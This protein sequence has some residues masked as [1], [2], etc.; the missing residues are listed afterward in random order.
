MRKVHNLGTVINFEIMRMLKKPGFWVMALGF[1]LIF[2]AI[3]GIIFWSNQATAEAAKK[4][5]EQEFSV[6]ILDHSG[7]VDQQLVSQ[8]KFQSVSSKQDG[9]ERVKSQSLDGFVYVP[10]D[11]TKETVEVYGQDVG[12]FQ[13]ER[14]STVAET[15]LQASVDT[16]TSPQVKAILQKH[17]RTS[18]TTY[19]NGVEY[20]VL[21]EMIVPGFFLVLFY[22]LITFFGNQML[23]STVEEKENRT[24]EMLLTTLEAKTLITGKIIS[25]VLLA[26]IQGLIIVLPML[27]LYLTLGKQLQIPEINLSGL[28]FDP[29]RISIAAAIFVTGFM[30]FTGLLVAAGAIMPTAKEAASWFSIVML[31]LFAPLYGATA[32]VSY[33]DSPFVQFFSYFPLTSPIPLLLRNAVGNLQLHQALIAIT[34]LAVSA[35]VVTAIAVRLFRYGA[36]SYDSRLSLSA[37]RT[38]RKADTV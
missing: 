23:N 35:V 17:I 14:Y 10:A 34:I 13:N 4:L 2:A 30:L 27:I 25:M 37:L 3:I 1:P 28:I 18:S 5:Q 20:D 38:K 33:P 6:A 8:M 24:V 9:I 36:M 26:M 16:K 15:V 22:I 19:R 29:V 32:F 11:I 31:L 12:L 7:L 21:K